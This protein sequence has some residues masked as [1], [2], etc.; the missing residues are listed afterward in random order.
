MIGTTSDSVSY[1]D[2][3]WISSLG[4]KGQFQKRR[5]R[6]KQVRRRGLNA[7]FSARIRGSGRS[8][9]LHLPRQPSEFAAVGKFAV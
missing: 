2:T 6:G 3:G 1:Q 9:K 5:V 4:Q 8:G 7:E